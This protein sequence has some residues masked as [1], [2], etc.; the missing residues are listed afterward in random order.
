MEA[1]FLTGIFFS[2]TAQAHWFVI[3]GLLRRAGLLALCF[4][5]KEK[6]LLVYK[7]R[8]KRWTVQAKTRKPLGR[9]FSQ[10][11]QIMSFHIHL[12]EA[13]HGATLTNHQNIA[14]FSPIEGI[15]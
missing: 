8:N 14:C 7:K 13:D 12:G 6:L 4:F 9:I 1:S 11:T 10:S 3:V 5:L 2:S 15:K